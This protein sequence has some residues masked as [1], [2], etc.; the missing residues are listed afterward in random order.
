MLNQ[1]RQVLV[2]ILERARER[3]RHL[4]QRLLIYSA[5]G[6]TLHLYKVHVF[7][8]NN[9]AWKKDACPPDKTWLDV[10]GVGCYASQQRVGARVSFQS[11]QMNHDSGA[12]VVCICACGAG[13]CANF[14]R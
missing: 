10:S 12:F 5:A 3:A 11:N 8:E 7:A 4:K 9:A 6:E 14:L 1:H 13:D 2:S